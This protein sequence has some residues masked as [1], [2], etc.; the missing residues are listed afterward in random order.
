MNVRT[1]FYEQLLDLPLFQ[2]LGRNDFM[3]IAEKVKFSFFKATS[4]E[5]V[6]KENDMCE[7]LIFVLCGKIQVRSVSRDFNYELTE[8]I[9]APLVIQPESLFG[10]SPQFSRTYWVDPETEYLTIPKSDVR[11]LLFNYPTFRI[12]YLNILS[13]QIQHGQRLLWRST[14]R[15]IHNRF[16]KFLIE[17][18]SRPA[19]HKSLKIKMTRLAEEILDTRL[20]TSKMLHDLADLDLLILERERIEIPQAEILFQQFL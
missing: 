15:S 4:C 20:N 8:F 18:S 9:N 11:D 2:G 13:T 12:N 1:S 16:A 17:R 6:A 5:S 19:G 10:L 3:E 14:S 7:R